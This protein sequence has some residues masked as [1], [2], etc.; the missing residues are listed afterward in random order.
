MSSFTTQP[1]HKVENI[2]VRQKTKQNRPSQIFLK[3]IH[4]KRSAQQ[5]QRKNPELNLLEKES[6]KR[7]NT[8]L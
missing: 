5:K 7:N 4:L 6:N 1:V 3:A 8:K 2:E